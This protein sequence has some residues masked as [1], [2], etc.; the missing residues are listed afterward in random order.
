[1]QCKSDLGSPRSS[2]DPQELATPVAESTTAQCKGKGDVR[3]GNERHSP[4]VLIDTRKKKGFKGNLHAHSTVSDGKLSPEQV[5]RLY[6]ER[7]YSFLAFSEHQCYTY[8]HDLQAPD[9]IVLPAIEINASFGEPRRFFHA[10]GILG[11]KSLRRS[12]E[13]P[14]EHL[15]YLD[16]PD[17]RDYPS[18]AQRAINELRESGHLV[19]FNH[20][21]WSFNSYDDLVS[22]D[23]YFAVEIYNYASDVETGIG[24]S[25]G[26]WDAVLRSG[27]KVW[28]VAADDN[29]NRNKFGEAP[30][31]WDSLGGWVTVDADEL[32]HD[33]IAS[34]LLQGKF[35]SSMGPEIHYLGFDG[36]K[37]CVEC[38]PVKSIYFI[39]YFHHGYSRRN[40][41]GG[42]VESAEY[43]IKGTE[44][45]IRV[46]CV[47]EKGRIAWS[48]PIFP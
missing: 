48:N 36:N 45:Y 47:D 31:E 41:N 22:L 19:M 37:V 24:L 43:E 15:Q 18:G 35:Y 38:S 6:R 7:G 42:A 8:H 34:S 26:H 10:N 33:A 14:Y 23:G 5:A 13:L 12:S 32:S 40:K 30:Q 27:R 39:S 11:P 29:H 25:T 20:P 9:F 44:K 17:L 1:M 21:E 46:E 16:V 28:G 3:V 4:Q 2:Q